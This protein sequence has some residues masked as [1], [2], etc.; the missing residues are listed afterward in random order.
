MPT[1]ET[2]G[3]AWRTR[4]DQRVALWVCRQD[5][6]KRGHPLKTQRLWIGSGQPSEVEMEK[7]AAAC[8]R[9]QLEMYDWHLKPKGSKRIRHPNY[10][11]SVYFIGCGD[12]IKIGFAKN[13][14]RRVRALQG[15][16]PQKLELLATTPGT[17]TDEKRMH[18]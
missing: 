2:P 18:N 17:P 15:T 10:G 5:I 13:V 7:I 14:A 4:G 6:A 16:S 9:L 3:L 1:S 8:Q 12:M 11:G